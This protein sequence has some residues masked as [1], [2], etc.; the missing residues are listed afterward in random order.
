[1]DIETAKKIVAAHDQKKPSEVAKAVD[2]LYQKFGTYQSITRVMGKSDKFWIVRHRISQLP[3][4]ILWKI[5]EGHIGIEQA[6]Q[7]TRLKQ[8]EDKWILA[9]AIVEVKGL[10]AKECGKVVNLVIKE[11]KSIMDSLS[12]LAGIHFDEIQPLSLPL[13]SDIWTEIC[14]IAWTQRQRWEDLCYQLVRQGVDVNIQEVA[15]Q[16]EGLAVDLRRSGRT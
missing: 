15:S 8:E 9:I 5:D 16:L 3:I 10:T 4:G 13:G 1:M 6:Y 7:I 14:K 2:V 12:I 11:G